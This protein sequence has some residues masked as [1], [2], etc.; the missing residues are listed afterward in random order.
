MGGTEL[1]NRSFPKHFVLE[2]LNRDN[3]VS[4]IVTGLQVGG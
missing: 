1:P 2:M 3:S 4:S